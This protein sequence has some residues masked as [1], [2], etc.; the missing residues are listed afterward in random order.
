MMID[1]FSF[2]SRALPNLLGETREVLLLQL[3]KQGWFGCGGTK[4]L[5]VLKLNCDF[6]VGRDRGFTIVYLMLNSKQEVAVI[7]IQVV[8]VSNWK[9]DPGLIIQQ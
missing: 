4:D 2:L 9:S 3:S 1:A 7:N 8:V 6:S 5:D